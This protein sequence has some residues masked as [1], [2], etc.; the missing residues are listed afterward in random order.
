MKDIRI[1]NDI[2]VIW[3][4]YSDQKPFLLD[5]MNISVYL[6]GVYEK[7]KIEDYT[8]KDNEIHWTFFGKDQKHTGG[9]SLTL[10]VNEG[11]KGMV[12]TDVCDLVRLVSCTCYTD[13]TDEA[14]VQTETIALTSTIN[15]VAGDGIISI[16]IDSELS[17]ESTNPV[18][19]KVITKK[20]AELSAKIETQR[21]Y[22]EGGVINSLGDFV[23]RDGYAYSDYIKVI[24]GKDYEINYGEVNED[25][26]LLEYNTDKVRVDYW[27]L[28][29]YSTKKTLTIG[30]NTHYLR[31]SFMTNNV[32]DVSVTD[33]TNEVW[34]ALQVSE[35]DEAV[36]DI[37]KLKK[38]AE[39]EAIYETKTFPFQYGR[40]APNGALENYLSF[41]RCRIPLILEKENVIAITA[42]ECEIVRM[43]AENND[44]NISDIDVSYS[45]IGS[46]SHVA[47]WVTIARLDARAFAEYE[48]SNYYTT[49]QYRSFAPEKT[50]AISQNVDDNQSRILNIESNQL[51]SSHQAELEIAELKETINAME[52]SM[53]AIYKA[54]VPKDAQ[55]IELPHDKGG[56]FLL[57]LHRKQNNGYVTKNNAYLPN[58]N[59]DFS[60]VCV[61]ANGEPLA[62]SKIFSGNIDIL[63]D[64]RLL[65]MNGSLMR[66]SSDGTFYGS[67]SKK[68]YKSPD[69]YAWEEMSVFSDLSNPSLCFIDSQDNIYVHDKGKLY[70]SAAPHITKE[71]VL[72]V[73][74]YNSGATINTDTFV[75]H[76]TTHRLFTAS[77]QKDFDIHILSSDD[78]GETWQTRYRSTD[79]YQHI[80]MLKIDIY[81]SAI[82]AGCDA[83][84]GILK[85]TD[86]GNTWVDLRALNPSIPQATDYGIVYCDESGY[87]LTAGE[88]AIVGGYST[89]KTND[90]FN[91]RPVLACGKPVYFIEKL[92]GILFGGMI[93]S[94]HNR[95]TGIVISKDDGETWITA[96][97]TAPLFESGSSDGYKFLTKCND[98]LVCSL[99][100]AKMDLSP[101][102]IYCGG[103][104]YYAQMIVDVPQGVNSLVVECGH[105]AS[106]ITTIYN[107]YEAKNPIVHQPLTSTM[108][109]GKENNHLHLIDGGRKIGE[110]FPAIQ[111]PADAQAVSIDAGFYL[112][113]RNVDLSNK[114]FHIG[115]WYKS[116]TSAEDKETEFRRLGLLS[117]KSISQRAYLDCGISI[118]SNYFF[119]VGKDRIAIDD[120][121]P[122]IYGGAWMRIDINFRNDGV[123]EFYVNGREPQIV[124]LS[125]NILPYL[126]KDN[127]LY[128]Y[129]PTITL[130]Y[131][132]QNTTLSGIQHFEI[133]EG[134][135][136]QDE[137]IKNFYANIYDVY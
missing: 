4:L 13:G 131:F 60:D 115:F 112:E 16:E 21:N 125:D 15:Y 83:G 31:I 61:M 68:V 33:G 73:K 29:K 56:K 12:T 30:A 50:Y 42:P 116:P 119:R 89:L 40:V 62:M 43:S 46:N 91:F 97:T 135:I 45:F 80:H 134:N 100:S 54:G 95:S 14:G 5:G 137:A 118:D 35:V 27:T 123:A 52:K 44:G 130:N 108:V 36:A 92:N 48:L 132:A 104:H 98:H 124:E 82:Y 37:S 59:K 28:V 85:S 53:S 109:A 17:E 128:L 70:R 110:I 65:P 10:V 49:N 26:Y 103:E 41:L 126:T 20:L 86:N 57:N 19:N 18:E 7:T 34:R 25:V 72:D 76:P 81:T 2:S 121:Y 71:I 78:F 106:K 9:Y 8:I 133:S 32:N 93:S 120:L 63:P 47:V 69:S 127:I 117:A 3:S 111:S 58:A 87:R 96:M 88:T 23:Q 64:E 1:G 122:G 79:T 113:L 24:P 94:K 39:E 101:V 136:T 105:Y 6:K 22:T 102:R 67:Y 66:Q 129:Q 77:Y 114:P 84:G 75:E 90:D 38:N 74:L 51:S 55:T 99:Q 107:N 11:A